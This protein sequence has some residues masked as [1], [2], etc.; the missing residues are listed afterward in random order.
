M[1][2]I[3]S[4]QKCTPTERKWAGIKYAKSQS[5]NTKKYKFSGEKLIALEFSRLKKLSLNSS[6]TFKIKIFIFRCY[7]YI[8]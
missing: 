5:D 4:V 3:F 8:N 2:D 6:S 7:E 1:G